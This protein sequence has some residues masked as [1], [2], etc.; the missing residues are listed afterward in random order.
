MSFFELSKL[1]VKEIIK[2]YHARAI[3][4]GTMSY[5]FWSVE[6]GAVIPEHS[7]M[8]EQVANV[9]KGKFELTVNGD[10]RLLE[11]GMVAVIPPHV[12]H[13]GKAITACEL[14]DVF[15]PER[16]DYKF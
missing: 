9:L 14:L 5:L 15:R 10:T 3:H 11:P 2:G 12:T 13:S 4:T 6:E 7:H 1:P 8:H 16:E